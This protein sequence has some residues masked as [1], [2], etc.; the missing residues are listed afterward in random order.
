MTEIQNCLREK[1][2]HPGGPLKYVEEVFGIKA[3]RGTKYPNLVS[4]KY[5]QIASPMGEKLVQE[6]RGIVLDQDND[7]AIV[8]RGFDKFF[9][10]GESH[11]API[12]WDS[13]RVLEKLDGSL[14][15]V[16]WYD[17]QARVA[18]SGHPEAGGSVGLGGSKSFADLFWESY[19]EPGPAMGR[20]GETH[21]YE[22]CT[23]ENQ[24]V[25]PH[26]EARLYLIGLR[27]H[28]GQEQPIW[29]MKS[30]RASI[31]PFFPLGSLSEC[32]GALD[33]F[34]GFHQEGFVVIDAQFRRIKIKHPQY[35]ALHRLKSRLSDKACLEVAR[36][37]ETHELVAY[38]PELAEKVDKWNK[39]LDYLA[40][41]MERAY[42]EADGDW[43]DG[44]QK[45]FALKVAGLPFSGALFARRN[46]KWKGTFREYLGQV[47]IRS[48][49]EYFG[50]KEEAHG[51]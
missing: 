36:L 15:M 38:F 12:D 48:L 1:A 17:G 10:Y 13:A 44:S 45:D 49:Q 30:G 29:R 14:M 20:P 8:A 7:W 39:E 41:D 37:G 22:L 23:P 43:T 5:S 21:M 4:L 47:N 27:D 32:L 9:N 2:S 18:S 51:D 26:K 24:V 34:S 16:Y 11:A 46:G 35:V 25:V 28:L 50:L 31:P 19:G 33:A 6:C 3:T 42:Y 40:S